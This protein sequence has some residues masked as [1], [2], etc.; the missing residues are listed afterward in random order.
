MIYQL[1]TEWLNNEE[2]VYPIVIDPTISN[3]RNQVNVLDT[4]VHPGDNAS[5]NHVNEDRLW[6]G[7]VNGTSRAFMNWADLPIINGNINTAHISFNYFKGTSTWGPLSVF[8]VNSNWNSLNLTWDIHKGLNYTELKSNLYPTYTN[9]YQNFSV[10]VTNTIR[11]WYNGS[12]GKYGFMVRYTNESYNDYN[13][14]VS[15]DSGSNS[16]FWP[17]LWINYNTDKPKAYTPTY[18]S[19]ILD[20]IAISAGNHLSF[21]GYQNTFQRNPSQE[22]ISANITSPISILVGHGDT[23]QV[24][25]GDRII[26]TGSSNVWDDTTS[27][28]EHLTPKRRLKMG[29]GQWDLSTVDLMV[30]AACATAFEN[31]VVT[32]LPKQAV[33]N[34]VRT[35]VGWRQ[36]IYSDSLQPFVE[37]FLVA[38]K[39]GMTINDAINQAKSFPYGDSR[40]YDVAIFGLAN[41]KVSLPSSYT[42]KSMTIQKENDILKEYDVETLNSTE[43]SDI[44]NFIKNEIN[45]SF[46]INDY[47]IEKIDNIIRLVYA[48]SNIRTNNIYTAILNE[49]KVEK[50]YSHIEE[51]FETLNTIISTKQKL[52]TSTEN[53]IKQNLLND[54]TKEITIYQDGYKLENHELKY[55]ILYDVTSNSLSYSDLY[56]Q[57]IK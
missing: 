52:D 7:K 55:Y 43:I 27:T 21:W 1:D 37:N 31:N 18:Y 2:R 32:P 33:Q 15:S 24:Y 13:T 10:N 50:I 8:R 14:I 5:H 20:D 45:I 42:T 9:G 44:V 53:Q 19:D 35:S 30:F 28:P 47:I 38:L 57:I 29:I 23:G 46:D 3:G 40:I 41:A 6:V 49:N 56:E 48:P 25:L 11:G 4:Y 51:D 39:S 22:D 34:G 12:V 36:R 17:C 26:S 54:S 16:D